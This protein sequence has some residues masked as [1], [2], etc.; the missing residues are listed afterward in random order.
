MK[1]RSSSKPHFPGKIAFNF[2]EFT[3]FLV[4]DNESELEAQLGICEAALPVVDR[5][6]YRIVGRT[7]QGK[8]YVN[9]ANLH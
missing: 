1:R 8:F 9:G 2:T 6:Q 7:G 4:L 3:V 5:V